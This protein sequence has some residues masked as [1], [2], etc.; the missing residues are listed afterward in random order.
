MG[1]GDGRVARDRTG[2]RRR[3]AQR[4]ASVA[5]GAPPGCDGARRSPHRGHGGCG[6]LARAR[7]HRG[8]VRPGRDRDHHRGRRRS[9]RAGAARRFGTDRLIPQR[10]PDRSRARADRCAGLN[11]AEPRRRRRLL[12]LLTPCRSAV[13]CRFR[14]DDHRPGDGPGQRGHLPVR[15][16]DRHIRVQRGLRLLPGRR[17]CAGPRD[18]VDGV[19]LGW[20]AGGHARRRGA[21]AGALHRGGAGPADRGE[22]FLLHDAP[23]V[24]RAAGHEHPSLC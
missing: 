18:R 17:G 21:D 19:W 5:D 3:Y 6:L 16:R 8:A 1:L 24:L 15:W 13:G 20:P 9:V 2:R 4:G 11:R 22:G 12:R 10:R 14:R 23:P 7:H